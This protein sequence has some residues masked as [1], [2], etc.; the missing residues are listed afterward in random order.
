MSGPSLKKYH[1]HHSIHEGVYVEARELTT[2]LLKSIEEKKAENY[3]QEIT[4]ALIEHWEQRMLAHADSEEEGLF[5][6]R[7]AENPD[8]LEIVAKLK[9]DH[10]IMGILV[11]EIKTELQKEKVINEYVLDR[12]KAL[13]CMIQIHNREEEKHMFHE[14]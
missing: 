12:F 7:L 9:R 13:L 4:N 14:H 1:S 6:E 2:L 10:Q 3:I 8:L 5:K 11:E